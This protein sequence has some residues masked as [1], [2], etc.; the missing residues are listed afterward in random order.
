MKKKKKKKL[1]RRASFFQND[2]NSY[3]KMYVIPDMKFNLSALIA[4]YCGYTKK[5]VKMQQE[6]HFRNNILFYLKVD[7]TLYL[8]CI[9]D[10]LI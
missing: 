7:S 5:I 9:F 4:L 3:Y 10:M 8:T 1:F 2:I 6:L